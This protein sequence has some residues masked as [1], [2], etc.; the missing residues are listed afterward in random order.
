MK[1]S[2]D[3]ASLSRRFK[4]IL[5][6]RRKEAAAWLRLKTG[7]ST[8]PAC[9]PDVVTG[10]DVRRSILFIDS[11]VPEPDR[12]AGSRSVFAYVKF[13]LRAGWSVKFIADN[14][15]ASQPHTRRL[16]E[17]GV[18]MLAGDY[19]LLHWEKWLKRN[20][21]LL[22]AVF[23]SRS[24]VAKQ[25]LGPVRLSTRAPVLFYGHDLLSHTLRQA[26]EELGN[27]QFLQ[28]ARDHEVAETVAISG[29]DFTFYPSSEEVR[30]L[31]Q[32]YPEKRIARLPLCFF[33]PP[34]RNGDEAKTRK[35]ILFVG[36]FD[37][38]PNE[39][40]VLW[41]V[42]TAWP[43]VSKQ[44][45]DCVFHVAGSQ[46]TKKIRALAAKRI[47]VHG[48]LPENDLAAL[49][50]NC[51]LS[52]APLRYGGGIKGKILQAMHLGT[53]VV[54]T[55]IGAAGLDWL[56]PTMAVCPLADFGNGVAALYGD[57][58]RQTDL[59][60]NAWDFLA[61]EFSEAALRTALASVLDGLL[62]APHH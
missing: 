49:H 45:P 57:E 11:K 1:K 44:W 4:Q 53:P 26:G 33:E 38:R 60:Q 19:Y 48:Y 62:T 47:H 17:M 12:D 10:G 28:A 56:R 34:Q 35:D 42:A 50:R 61:A 46:P 37:H 20:G 15:Q 54:T 6:R 51:R 7:R 30:L 58:P 2:T 24:H 41:F 31:S 27:P 14:F 5:R 29:A 8:C 40:A 55:P 39:D 13:F 32:R 36:G 22:D 21:L 3:Q 59:R 52:V 43:I 9:L 25:W 23:I 16:E 18:E